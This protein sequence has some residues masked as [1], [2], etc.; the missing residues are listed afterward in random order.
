MIDSQFNKCTDDY[1]KVLHI[2]FDLAA[3]Y[4]SF[5]LLY[6]NFIVGCIPAL[7]P[8]EPLTSVLTL[9][10]VALLLYR[11]YTLYR[12]R[13]AGAIL[14]PLVCIGV[15]GLS[16]L[17]CGESNILLLLLLVFGLGDVDG[18]TV[19]RLWICLTSLVLLCM[20]TL[21]F[22]APLTG[23]E[24]E[25]VIRPGS[26]TVRYGLYFIHPNT[27]GMVLG[28]L[29]ISL[30][31]VW[32][33][34]SHLVDIAC[35]ILLIFAY[36]VTDSKG[37]LIAGSVY[38]ILKTMPPYFWSGFSGRLLRILPILCIGL[39]FLVTTGMLNSAFF[40]LLQTA[41]TGRPALWQ[42]QFKHVGLTLFGQ[43][44]IFGAVDY[45]GWHYSGITID[46]A[47]ASYLV[48]TGIASFFVFQYLYQ[49][50]FTAAADHHDCRFLSA[51]AGIALLG[52][53]ESA[54]INPMMVVPLVLMGS[55]GDLHLKGQH[56]KREE[57]LGTLIN[58]L[59]FTL[60]NI[61]SYPVDSF[62]LHFIKKPLNFLS[63]KETCRLLRDEGYSLARFGDGE[64]RWILGNDS[65]PSFQEGSTALSTALKSA[66]AAKS[67]DLLIAI[68]R[69]L[70]DDRNLRFH[71][72]S[73]WRHTAVA[74]GSDLF[75]LLDCNREYA[76]ALLTRPYLDLK[77][78]KHCSS[79]FEMIKSIWFNRNVLIIEGAGTRFGV[80]NDLLDSCRTV[81][82]ILCPCTNAFDSI[83]AIRTAVWQFVEPADMVLLCLGPTA[84]VLAS[85]FSQYGIQSIDIGHLDVE[86]EWMRQGAMDK[87]PV[88]GRSVNEAGTGAYV[89][90]SYSTDEYERQIVAWI[91]GQ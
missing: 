79:H 70:V 80:G 81:R 26:G 14:I 72:R 44:A 2:P 47:Y 82:R 49:R 89:D 53:V 1:C 5:I 61:I 42:F 38:F 58:K 76:D 63:D 75:N 37:A 4:I 22:L 9:S 46:S 15:G 25:L 69:S 18:K 83:D 59:K 65:V 7:S 71:A 66:L 20:V 56:F 29:S 34:K 12:Q 51:L 86:Y 11:I 73:F 55:Y 3:Y 62:R 48:Y 10:S 39:A 21:V 52:I 67:D 78:K 64:L 90:D 43:H 24:P 54:A 32:G 28:V 50:A 19:F 68:P 33:V 40:N 31:M 91:E 84:S 41:L 30:S 57:R 74:M 6:I 85:E 23:F 27:L 16:F 60:R 87:V 17:R 45:D 8:L 77:D 13:S 36:I 88:Y 35:S